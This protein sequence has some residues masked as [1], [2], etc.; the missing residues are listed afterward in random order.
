VMGL[1]LCHLARRL[2]QW[3]AE[4]GTDVP[5]ACQSH[6]GHPCRIYREIMSL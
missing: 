4:P 1:P 2:R 3:G 6:T 5:A